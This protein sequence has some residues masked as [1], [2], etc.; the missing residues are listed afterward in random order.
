MVS[1]LTSLVCLGKFLNLSV[2]YFLHLKK[3]KSVWGELNVTKRIKEGPATE[4]VPR[5][6]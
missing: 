1:P 5:S 3:K 4:C 2:P 6:C